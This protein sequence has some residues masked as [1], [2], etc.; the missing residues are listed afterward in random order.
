MRNLDIIMKI[1]ETDAVQCGQGAVLMHNQDIFEF[2]N[3]FTCQSFFLQHLPEV[4]VIAYRI[5]DNAQVVS[6]FQ[7]VFHGL[8]CVGFLI[9]DFR[10]LPAQRSGKSGESI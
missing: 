2:R 8:Q 10:I 1:R 6:N 4:S 9:K 5:A 3:D 7:N